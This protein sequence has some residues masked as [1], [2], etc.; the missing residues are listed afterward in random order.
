MSVPSRWAVG[1]AR[2]QELRVDGVEAR[3]IDGVE[4]R[5]VD[6]VGRHLTAVDD[7]V[8]PGRT[9]PVPEP[10]PA[11]WIGVPIGGGQA[12]GALAVHS[13]LPLARLPLSALDAARERAV[14]AFR[15]RRPRHFSLATTHGGARR[16]LLLLSA[17]ATALLNVARP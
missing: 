4:G 10:V 17:T 7:V 14:A 11:G 3:R 5:R 1:I 8:R 16:W 6:G 2:L 9:I 12:A 13:V 15:R